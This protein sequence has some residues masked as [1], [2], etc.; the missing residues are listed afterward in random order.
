L[1]RG[2]YAELQKCPN[3]DASHY[4]S[5]ADFDVERV[6]TSKCTK[7]K[8]GGNKSAGVQ[9]EEESSIGTETS[10]QRKVPALVMWYLPV[11]DH[12]KRLFS[13]PKTVELMT[14]HADRPE[15]SDGKLRHPSD[16]WQCWTFD[17]THSDFR[18]Q[19][20]NIRFTLCTDVMY[21]FGE[22]SST[23]STW[24]M[25]MTIYNLPP[26]HVTRESSFFLPL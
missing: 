24:P 8:V 16:A 7:R 5:N 13:I 9:V 12:L 23:H 11:E 6:V 2:D 4:K 15:K 10:S 18:D 14:S 20:I 19:K 21:P 25:L 3:C 1:Y 22:R 17:S 26:S